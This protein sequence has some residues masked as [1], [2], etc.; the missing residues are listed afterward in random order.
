MPILE[1]TLSCRRG[2]ISFWDS[3]GDGPALLM[4]HGTGAAKDVFER[5]F[6][7]SLAR[8]YRLIA[9]DLPGHGKSANTDNVQQGYSLE[10]FASTVLEFVDALALPA[11]VVFGW[12]LGGHIAIEMVRIRP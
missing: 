8:D 9:M 5:Q 3:L 7:S 11:P 1:R 2:D 12:S 4:L 6:S 10:G